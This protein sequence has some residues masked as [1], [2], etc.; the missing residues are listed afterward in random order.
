[1]RAGVYCRQS[2]DRDGTE[3]GV[4]RQEQECRKLAARRGDEIVRVLV[5]NNRSASSGERPGYDELLNLIATKQIDVVLVLRV[6]RLLRRLTDLEALIE[7]S[8][9]T[10]VQI[11][12]VEGDIDLGSSSGRLIARILASVARSEV[13]T[14]SA[15]QQLANAQRAALGL[16]YGGKRPYGYLADLTTINPAEAAVMREMA[17]RIIAGHGF[18]SVAWWANENNHS[19]VMGKQWHPINIRNMLTNKR[20]AGIREYKG[21]EYPAIW[22]PVFDATTWERLQLVIQQ[23]SVAWSRDSGT[24][25]PRKYL[26]TGILFCGKCGTPLNGAMKHDERHKAAPRRI[27]AC[28]QIG[29]QRRAHGCGGIARGADPLDD[30]IKEC[31]IA[32]LDTPE[33]SN[34]LTQGE[35]AGELR[36]LLASRETLKLRLDG[37]VDDYATGLLNRSQF[38][39]AKNTAESELQALQSRIDGLSRQQTL[40]S[41]PAGQTV[42]EAWQNGSNEWRRSLIELLVKRIVV[43]AGYARKP[44]YKG[45]VFDPDAIVVEWIV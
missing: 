40:G 12:T 41:I 33:L 20:Y 2:L 36:E 4:E 1:M 44:R 17:R 27:Y 30:W 7:L 45:F 21:T 31:V 37:L 32:R 34:L 10:G 26:L 8:E 43:N 35:D 28:R 5:D 9:R 42:R 6:D 19:T 38:T 11:A 15:R 23:R 24:T 18:K 22:E 14:K 16:P 3:L 13:E 39:R 25:K 29:D